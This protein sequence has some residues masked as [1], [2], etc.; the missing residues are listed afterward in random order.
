MTPAPTSAAPRS[1][2]AWLDQLEPFRAIILTLDG[3]MFVD[4]FRRGEF[5]IFLDGENYGDWHIAHLPSATVLPVFFRH[6]R[7]AAEAVQAIGR[8]RNDWRDADHAAFL[9]LLPSILDIG[10]EFNGAR[11][12]TEFIKQPA[13]RSDL[14]GYGAPVAA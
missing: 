10:K 5:A 8:L 3:A 6:A 7:H 12:R 13:L 2:F 1:C 11:W 14:N 4:S 9:R